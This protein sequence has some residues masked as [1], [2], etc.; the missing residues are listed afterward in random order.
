MILWCNE[1]F[2]HKG[3]V[4]RQRIYILFLQQVRLC[5]LLF[6]RFKTFCLDL[7]STYSPLMMF[8]SLFRNVVDLWQK[9]LQEKIIKKDIMSANNPN[10]KHENVQNQAWKREVL[11]FNLKRVKVCIFHQSV[12]FPTPYGLP[13]NH[14]SFIFFSLCWSPACGL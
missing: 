9:Y 6:W 12:S 2:T 1:V 14:F 5:S 7:G 8:S 3:F 4:E 11:Q 13:V 10:K